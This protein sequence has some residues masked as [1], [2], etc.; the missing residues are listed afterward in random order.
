MS[1]PLDQV[2][3]ERIRHQIKCH[4]GRAKR[5]VADLRAFLE[6]KHETA[7]LSNT[8]RYFGR[9]ET[10]VSKARPRADKKPRQTRS[11]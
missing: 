3:I 1:V 7:Q 6:A 5:L 10:M 4:L 11:A 2:S 9:P 8:K